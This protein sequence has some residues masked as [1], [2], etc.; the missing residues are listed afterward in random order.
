[1]FVYGCER[2][3]LCTEMVINYGLGLGLV[4]LIGLVEFRLVRARVVV[5]V[6]VMVRV[7]C[8]VAWPIVRPMQ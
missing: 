4:G 8:R 3:S 5:M 2:R 6:S 7:S 1:M